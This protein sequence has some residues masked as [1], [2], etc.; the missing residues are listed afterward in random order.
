MYRF[1]SLAIL[2]G[3]VGLF[4]LVAYSLFGWTGVV[5]IVAGSLIFNLF[6]LSGSARMILS[7]HR[8]H[9]ISEW[10]MPA[11]HRITKTLALRANIPT[12]SLAIYPSDMPNAFALGVGNGVVAL[13]SGLLR[14]LDRR[15]VAGVLAHEFA[16]LKNRDSLL[17]L[18]AG[19]F[20][21]A[22]S[23]LSTLFGILVFLLFISGAWLSI[24][25]NLI[26][27]ILL[28]S[29]APYGAIFLHATLMRTRE[30]LADRD[31]VM[32]T[33]DPGGLG[34]AL[35]KLEQAN[36]YLS[37]LQ[38]R[39]RFIYT[40]DANTGSRWLRTHPPTEE[41]VRALCELSDRTRPF[42]SAPVLPASRP[43][44]PRRIVIT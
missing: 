17:N 29:I 11:L 40:S 12:P 13:S 5:L 41:R 25:T 43:I 30:F 34:N 38:R 3:I 22:I 27:L 26:P 14:L 23:F 33:G 18:S 7:F 15:E 36:R 21:R 4:A 28:T 16:H 2:A 39:F 19:L 32:L 20:V 24:G 1:Q 8:A 37:R 6:S 10:E 42:P 44:G 35:I 31:A 9:P